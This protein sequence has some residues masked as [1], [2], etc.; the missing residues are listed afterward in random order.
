MLYRHLV[1]VGKLQARKA[2]G[3][4]LLAKICDQHEPHWPNRLNDPVIKNPWAG[5]WLGINEEVHHTT[6]IAFAKMSQWA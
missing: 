5:C 4:I 6:D 1:R 3:V 2:S